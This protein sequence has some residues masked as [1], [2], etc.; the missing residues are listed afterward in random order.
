MADDVDR[1]TVGEGAFD[2]PWFSAPCE[3]LR[4]HGLAAAD[5]GDRTRN[6]SAAAIPAPFGAL[7]RLEDDRPA[8]GLHPW[9]RTVPAAHGA[10]SVNQ[11]AQ[12]M[13]RR[14]SSCTSR[15]RA[16]HAKDFG[17]DLDQ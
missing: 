10:V 4:R 3:N 11:P 13:L 15:P 5:G 9:D 7:P 16:N 12:R 6:G 2:I 1:G 17:Y 8:S 14:S